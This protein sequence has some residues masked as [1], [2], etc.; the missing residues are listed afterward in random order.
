MARDQYDTLETMLSKMK[1]LYKEVGEY[2]AFDIKK[3]AFEEFFGDITTFMTEYDVSGSWKKK[4]FT[5]RINKNF[6]F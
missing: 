2:Y 3:K 6:L 4:I 1:T 5:G